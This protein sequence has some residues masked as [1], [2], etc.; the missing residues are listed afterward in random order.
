[1]RDEYLTC[2][3]GGGKAIG[4]ALRAMEQRFEQT[5]TLPEKITPT[6]VNVCYSY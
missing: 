6:F 1:M 4:F 5:G 3:K 2:G